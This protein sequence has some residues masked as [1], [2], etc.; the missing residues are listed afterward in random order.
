MSKNLAVNRSNFHTLRRPYLHDSES[1][2]QWSKWPLA[3]WLGFESRRKE[4]FDFHS[5]CPNVHL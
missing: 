3:T 5:G 1:L 2:G 4:K